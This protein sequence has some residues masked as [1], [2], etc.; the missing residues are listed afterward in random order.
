MPLDVLAPPRQLSVTKQ[1]HATGSPKTKGVPDFLGPWLLA[2]ADGWADLSAEPVSQFIAAGNGRL[3]VGAAD[4]DAVSKVCHWASNT[5][6]LR[7]LAMSDAPAAFE[8]LASGR[9]L[10]WFSLTGSSRSLNS[11]P[12]G[13]LTK[14]LRRQ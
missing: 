4:V 11:L 8:L 7:R 10:S 13:V 1:R 5:N 6:V 12:M 9:S 14:R 3:P 2:N